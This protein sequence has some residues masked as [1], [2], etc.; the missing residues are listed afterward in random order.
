MGVNLLRV[1]SGEGVGPVEHDKYRFDHL[2]RF[3]QAL[4]ANELPVIVPSSGQPMKGLY[5]LYGLSHGAEKEFRFPIL[6]DVSINQFSIL[7]AL[8]DGN[9]FPRKTLGIFKQA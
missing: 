8:V 1:L 7:S 4:I 5:Y 6:D 3:P 2:P 9:D